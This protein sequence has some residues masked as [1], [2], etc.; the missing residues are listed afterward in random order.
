MD[1]VQLASDVDNTINDFF[2][3]PVELHPWLGEHSALINE[4]FPDPTRKV[5]KT[6]GIYVCPGA[7]AIGE[8]GTVASGLATQV[9]SSDEWL[10]ITLRDLG[11]DPSVWQEGDRVFFPECR[12]GQDPWH[13]ISFVTPSATNRF[14]INMLRLK[15]GSP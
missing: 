12:A 9:V 7:H 10:S 13:T 5:I 3:E 6:V 2:A 14:N 11:G 15:L 8:A 4:T 1:W